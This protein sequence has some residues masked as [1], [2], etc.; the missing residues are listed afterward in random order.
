[1]SMHQNQVKTG[2]CIKEIV[3]MFTLTDQVKNK[4]LN[5]VIT[6]TNESN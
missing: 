5:Q 3:Q 4:D 1:M 6:G 2:T